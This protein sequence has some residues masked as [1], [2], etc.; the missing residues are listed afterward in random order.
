VDNVKRAVWL[1][2]F[3]VLGL[4]LDRMYRLALVTICAE[5]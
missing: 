2:V 5:P 3:M 1:I 4:D